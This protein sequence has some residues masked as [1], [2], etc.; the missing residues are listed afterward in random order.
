MK[1]IWEGISG[2]HAAKSVLQNIIDSAKIPHAFLFKG[3]EG[4]GKEFTAVRF[5][6]ALNKRYSEADN[7]NAVLNS[8]ENLAEPFIKYIF[9]IPRGKNET[10]SSGPLEKLSG[11]DLQLLRDEL[12]VK[13]KNPYHKIK[14]PK[15]NNIKISSIRDITKFLS[16]NFTDVAYRFIVIADA[17][18]MNEEAQNALLKS[19][20]EPPEGVIFILSTPYPDLLRETIRSRCWSINFQPLNNIELKEV[21]VH[22]Y[23]IN[24]KLAEEIAPFASGSVVNALKLLDNNFEELL[25][26]TILI[27][28]YSFGRRYNSALEQFGKYLN[29]GSAESIKLIIQMIIIWLNDIQK[30]RY[31]IGDYYFNGYLET[32]EKFNKRFPGIDLNEIVVKLDRMAALLKNNININLAVLNIVFEL[33]DLITNKI[34]D[35]A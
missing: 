23:E 17:H 2:Q 13:I 9:P 8:I 14:L 29:E 19:L 33:S 3:I 11:D 27:L 32:L 24:D 10:D 4:T 35:T 16:Y 7:I 30:H 21:L 6:Q 1:D 22:C 12:A 34:K 20:E 31:G 28:R 26:K 5:A 15:A 18:M 25:E